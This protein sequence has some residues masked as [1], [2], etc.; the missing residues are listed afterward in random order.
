MATSANSARI[1]VVGAT[2]AVGTRLLS[3]LEQRGFVA[4]EL[5][6]FASARSIGKKVLSQGREWSCQVLAPGCFEGLDWVF[7]DASDEISREWV[8][9][10]LASRCI[11]IDNSAVYR[12]DP[13]VPLVVPEVNGDLAIRAIRGGQRLL[14]GPNCSTV[15][16]TAA[17]APLSRRY[18]LKR[19]VV[20][21]YQSVSGAGSAAMDELSAQMQGSRDRSI[22]PHPIAGNLIP[23]IGKPGEDGFTSEEQKLMQESRKILGL[24][25][26][27]IVATAVRVPT[28]ISHAESVFVELGSPFELAEIGSAWNSCPGIEWVDDPARDL[29]PTNETTAGR[30]A[31]SIGRLRRDPSVENGLCFWVVSDNLRKGAALNAVQIAETIRSVLP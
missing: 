23:R 26:L 17:L 3:I 2:G 5:R 7:F 30:D 6:L 15:Q 1:G 11:V 29:Y 19:V 10:A 14:A 20:S 8:P 18:G 28:Y 12:M 24:P 4:S 31:V 25:G 27:P 13:A 21:T 16:L 9:Q 22:F